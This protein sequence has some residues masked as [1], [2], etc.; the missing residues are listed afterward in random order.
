MRGFEGR[1]FVF[2]VSRFRVFEVRSSG[3]WGF[4][5]VV[6]KFGVSRFGVSRFGVSRFA[7]F[8]VRGFEVRGWGSG[9]RGS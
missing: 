8:E 5:N 1:G 6:S 3:F 2:G 4:A 7:V 9:F